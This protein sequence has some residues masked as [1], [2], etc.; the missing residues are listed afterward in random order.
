MDFNDLK[1]WTTIKNDIIKIYKYT[2]PIHGTKRPEIGKGGKNY[3]WN[4]TK[5]H[6]WTEAFWPGQLWLAYDDTKDKIFLD[7]ARVH[8]PAF[9]KMLETPK[10]LHHDVGFLF[11]MSSVSD[12]K[13]T[14][15]L[16]AKKRALRAADILRSRFQ[17]NGRYIQAWNTKPNNDEWN[18]IAVGKMIIDSMENIHLLYWASRVTGETA[19]QEIANEHALNMQKNIIREDGSTYHCFNF[20]PITGNPLGG[21]THQGY[22]N[23]SCWS[24]GQGWAIHGFAQAYLNSKNKSFLESAIFLADFV[25]DNISDDMVPIWDFK[26]PKTSPQIKDS[27]AGAIISA[28]ILTISSILEELQDNRYKK[29]Y[30]AGTDILRGLRKYCDITQIEGSQGLLNQGASHVNKGGYWTQAMLIYGDYY[31]YE[32]VLRALG[33]KDFVWTAGLE[34]K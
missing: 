25:I 34:E 20:D 10:W 13:T 4:Y 28:G 31:Y 22:S 17:W 33:K 12:Y 3:S 9:M 26:A 7:A 27:S 32:A 14:G 2:I 6:Y 15:D 21:S 11:L 30:K 8:I 19:Y 5:E 23:E 1:E 18:K 16:E 29:Y 24:R